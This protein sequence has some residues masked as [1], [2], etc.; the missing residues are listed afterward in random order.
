MRE[1]YEFDIW[2]YFKSTI[3]DFFLF[4]GIIVTVIFIGVT[5]FFFLNIFS[6]DFSEQVKGWFIILL[7]FIV[8]YIYFFIFF[9]NTGQT[10]GMKLFKYKVV[11]VD[12]KSLSFSQ[13]V[14]WAITLPVPII[15]FFDI[16]NYF[17]SSDYYWIYSPLYYDNSSF[18]D[19]LM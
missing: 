12:K 18:L 5:L 13:I 4:I 11:S 7:V 2:N 6:V 8:W 17:S 1:K 16:L 14:W 15:V 9:K 19:N 3:V 10:L